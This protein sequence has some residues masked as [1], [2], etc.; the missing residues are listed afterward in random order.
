MVNR[1]GSVTGLVA[2]VLQDPAGLGDEV[3]DAGWGHLQHVAQQLH[4]ADLALVEEGEHHPGGVVEQRLGPLIS[5]CAPGASA[6]LLAVAFLGPGGL[7]RGQLSTQL[8]EFRA[9]Q[10]GQARVRQT[11]QKFAASAGDAVRLADRQ[12]LW[13]GGFGQQGVVPL[14]VNLM[15]DQRQRGEAVLADRDAGGVVTGIQ[16]G[17]DA[18]TSPGAGGGDRLDNDFVAGQRPATPVVGDVG[19]QPVLDFVPFACARTMPL[20]E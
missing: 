17:L 4:R 1:L 12:G 8:C 18:Q 14:A 5:G 20:L 3:A 9:I 10:P 7:Q 13:R 19:E 11:G 16:V 2:V 6:A 15:P